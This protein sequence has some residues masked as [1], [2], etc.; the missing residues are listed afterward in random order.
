MR[1][2]VKVGVSYGTDLDLARTTLLAV[3]A[4]E[5]M[6]LKDP[7]PIVYHTGFGDSSIDLALV[8]WIDR[9]PDDVM[10]MSK[11]RFAIDA[12]F[13]SR[14]ITIPFPQRDVH[15][16]LLQPIVPGPESPVIRS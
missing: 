3:A 15:M 12:A 13:R 14:D 10:V 9:A 4:G 5:S 6:V 8:A 16:K 11:L 7:A 1:I 2:W